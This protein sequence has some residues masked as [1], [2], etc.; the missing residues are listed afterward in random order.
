M[1]YFLAIILGFLSSS[2]VEYCLHRFYLHGSPNSSHVIKHHKQ[3]IGE[4]FEQHEADIKKITSKWSYVLS[5]ILCYTPLSYVFFI[6][7]FIAGILYLLTGIFYTLWVE[8]AHLHYHRSG[9]DKIG[10][11]IIFKRLKQ[12]HVLHHDH[13]NTNFGVGS[14]VWDKILKK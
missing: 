8:Y 12:H 11:L 9:W 5:N 13:M 2:F 4:S 1:Y 14:V 7:N 6:K 3:F 10:R